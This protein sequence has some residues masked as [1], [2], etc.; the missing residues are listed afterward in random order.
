M[1]HNI[2]VSK[3][4]D[5]NMSHVRRI[6]VLLHLQTGKIEVT[7]CI[8]SLTRALDECLYVILAIEKVENI[9][10]NDEIALS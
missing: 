4:Y 8:C 9:E 3:S 5:I 6:R 1:Q 10:S 2:T 7:L